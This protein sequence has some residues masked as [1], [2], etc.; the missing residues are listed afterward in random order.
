MSAQSLKVK[1][2]ESQG[3]RVIPLT[4][5]SA[6]IGSAG[7]CD[8]VMDHP[9]VHSEHLRA[10]FDGGRIWI[11]DMGST[12]G[13]FLNGIRLPSLKPMLIRELDVLRL[14]DSPSTVGLETHFV[15][16]PVVRSGNTGEEKES[17]DR[18]SADDDMIKKRDELAK[19]RRELA[20]IKLQLQ[21]GRL[22]K[23]SEDE[24]HRQ[25]SRIR[26]EIQ[27]LRDQK[28]RLER[29]LRQ[30]ESNRQ[31]Q[32][33]ALEK[34][35]AERKEAALTQLKNLMDHEMSKLAEWKVKVMADIR[36][37]VQA[38]SQS[39]SRSWVTRPLS[40]DMILEWEA[41]IQAVI[42]KAMLGEVVGG[43]AERTPAVLAAASGSEFTG[44]DLSIPEPPPQ[45]GSSMINTAPTV[46]ERSRA[47]TGTSTT[48]PRL[49]NSRSSQRARHSSSRPV[50]LKSKSRRQK[51]ELVR[52]VLM[53]LLIAALVVGAI[54]VKKG[55]LPGT[56]S[57]SSTGEARQTAAV[58]K[59]RFDPV[60]TKDFKTTFTDNVLF[61]SSFLDVEMNPT[62]RTQWVSSFIKSATKDWKLDSTAARKIVEQELALI[63]DL[64]RLREN[65]DGRAEKPGIQAMREREAAFTTELSKQIKS[66]GGSD[67][68]WRLKRNF[69]GRHQAQYS[70]ARH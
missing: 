66:K 57:S 51:S 2:F 27:E 70:T 56:R 15:R 14:G 64:R 31:T 5:S 34:E 68:F 50:R 40:K 23:E 19:L 63:K 4:K 29:T 21:M 54:L 49:E 26:S 32:L 33:G 39:K 67:K 37:D 62:Y 6:N 8:V 47:S 48:P 30:M 9:S 52:I 42:R 53:L 43:E 16:S 7:H 3:T 24:A 55:L 35:L 61:T 59:L 12:S 28:I 1:I 18:D 44:T 65:I 36:V 17:K 60:T 41:D 13:T 11:Q 46:L 38:L 25:L 69:F 10:W 22:D 20:E 58:A 45:T